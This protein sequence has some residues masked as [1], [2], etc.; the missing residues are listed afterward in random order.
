MPGDNT[1]RRNN[2]RR[3]PKDVPH[4]TDEQKE[5]L[6]QVPGKFDI[7]AAHMASL[8]NLQVQTQSDLYNDP[9]SLV[10]IWRDAGVEYREASQEPPSMPQR[11]RRQTSTSN[12]S[13]SLTSGS[14]SSITSPQSVVSNPSQALVPF[15]SPPTGPRH[16]NGVYHGHHSRAPSG[17][18]SYTSPPPQPAAVVRP[19]SRM[20]NPAT[21]FFVPLQQQ[22]HPSIAAVMGSDNEPYNNNGSNGFANTG[23]MSPAV[24]AAIA[25]NRQAHQANGNIDISSSHDNDQAVAMAIA[26][27]NASF[28]DHHTNGSINS[29]N[30][31]NH[32]G[33]A[34]TGNMAANHHA[35]RNNGSI[36]YGNGAYASSRD[37]N[38]FVEACRRARIRNASLDF[39]NGLDRNGQGHVANG[40]VDSGNSN[41][42]AHGLGSSSISGNHPF[43]AN[44]KFPGNNQ[45]SP[46]R[47]MPALGADGND[48]EGIFQNG[49]GG[50]GGHTRNQSNVSN[51][52]HYSNASNNE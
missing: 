45:M 20:G 10:Q 13:S 41:R 35:R 15:T 28:Q 7:S 17:A 44:F 22:Q 51:H 52:S 2:Q 40:S 6:C 5:A 30:G 14:L 29:G 3:T 48:L 46:P 33:E 23:Q 42:D 43:A 25:A 19:G 34:P 8:I 27:M 4:M 1:P 50:G 16:G 38:I 39:S 26:A 12:T 32:N 47:A 18:S 36:D 37:A 24:A 9:R 21:A 49:G 11:Y 31:F